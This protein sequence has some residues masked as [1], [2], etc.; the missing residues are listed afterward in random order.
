MRPEDHFFIPFTI[1][2]VVGAVWLYAKWTWVRIL[3]FIYY[4]HKSGPSG[5]FTIATLRDIILDMMK[6]NGIDTNSMDLHIVHAYGHRYDGTIIV[7]SPDGEE[8]MYEMQITADDSGNISY[9][10]A[11]DN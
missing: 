7:K 5:Y 1:I 9:K 4:S 11:E 10:I 8:D 3:T 6:E 2:V